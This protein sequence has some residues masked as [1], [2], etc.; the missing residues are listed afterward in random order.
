ME[1]K[2][3]DFSDVELKAIAYDCLA[4][5]QNNQNT[6]NAIN[7]ELARRVRA[8]QSGA[9]AAV[10]PQPDDSGPQTIP[11]LGNASAV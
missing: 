11:R 8:A 2:L 10:I 5:I 6:L 7:E 1:K 9:G 3:T 4:T